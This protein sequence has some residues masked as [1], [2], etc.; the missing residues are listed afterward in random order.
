MSP[1]LSEV[2]SQPTDLS[3]EELEMVS[4]LMPPPSE[5]GGVPPDAVDVEEESQ[6]IE[7][8]LPD[9]AE[10]Y[11][12]PKP[13]EVDDVRELL[14][15]VWD[16]HGTAV[17]NSV[18]RNLIQNVDAAFD[19]ASNLFFSEEEEPVSKVE[20]SLTD[21]ARGKFAN[22]VSRSV[23]REFEDTLVLSSIQYKTNG[24]FSDANLGVSFRLKDVS[25][26]E[27]KS[28]IVLYEDKVETRIVFPSL[29][30]ERQKW[31]KDTAYYR[32]SGDVQFREYNNLLTVTTRRSTDRDV[33]EL[34]R[35]L[36]V[37]FNEVRSMNGVSDS[38]SV[39]ES[40][41][42]SAEE[43][44]DRYDTPSVDDLELGDTIRLF[45]R[46][47]SFGV[48]EFTVEETR[49]TRIV[50]APGSS[51]QLT[52]EVLD[53]RA[54]PSGEMPE[55]LRRDLPDWFSNGTSVRV[56]YPQ[57]DAKSIVSTVSN[58]DGS[59]FSLARSVKQTIVA[60][61]DSF[62]EIID[63]YSDLQKG[64]VLL[65]PEYGEVVFQNDSSYNT[66][67]VVLPDGSEEQLTVS[68]NRFFRE[69]EIDV[70][71]EPQRDWTLDKLGDER[72]EKVVS[73][74]TEF[75]E[76]NPFNVSELQA[77]NTKGSLTSGAP[78]AYYNFDNDS[79]TFDTK[80]ARDN[81]MRKA[82]KQYEEGWLAGPDLTHLALHEACHALHYTSF[83]MNAD[84]IPQSWYESDNPE[85]EAMAEY[86]SEYAEENPLEFVAE[87]GALIAAGRLEEEVEDDDNREAVR[88]AWEDVSGMSVNEVSPINE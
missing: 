14:S 19:V 59:V 41:L 84:D 46:D 1:E 5:P 53:E 33:K 63:R 86:V 85:Y 21:E 7:V 72:K 75:I 18:L 22:I 8:S 11:T 30:A 2:V 78:V 50:D 68:D 70:I 34:V 60:L 88:V 49:G 36:Y 45:D 4:K 79:I 57:S 81:H 39:D 73:T 25:K 61:G 20:E 77:E 26:S 40:D 35:K 32:L 24:D 38:E 13:V 12:L 74:V 58:L 9:V 62:Y 17:A 23:L 29:D 71:E 80:Q 51:S 43:I 66:Y 31:L 82:E 65:S 37:L 42:S 83:G 55:Q 27:K 10:E 87:T 15:A 28:Q 3:E 76:K 56:S 54:L 16:A 6:F 64:Q 47:N 69:V 52:Q 44:L 48:D 67:D